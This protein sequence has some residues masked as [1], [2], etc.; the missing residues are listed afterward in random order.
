[1]VWTDEYLVVPKTLTMIFPVVEQYC[2]YLIGMRKLPSD[3][4]RS[5]V[6]DQ[7]LQASLQILRRQSARSIA[8]GNSI[9]KKSLIE[10]RRRQLIR[11]ILP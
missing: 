8:S 9:E 5:T 2:T 3:E 4:R 11:I 7:S 6:S 1:M 10:R